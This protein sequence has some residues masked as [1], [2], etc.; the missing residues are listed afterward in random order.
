M[1]PGFDVRSDICKYQ[2][3]VTV[4]QFL[5]RNRQGLGF[6]K[7]NKLQARETVPGMVLANKSERKLEPVT[8]QPCRQGTTAIRCEPYLSFVAVQGAHG[9]LDRGALHGAA[10]H[11]EN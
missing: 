1:T 3:I 6:P 4:Q 2:A 8:N 11:A 7:E 10:V 5:Q 9:L